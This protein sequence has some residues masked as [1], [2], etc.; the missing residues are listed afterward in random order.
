MELQQ[1]TFV[2]C[3]NNSITV[4][5]T[6]EDFD[7]R[8]KQG[9]RPTYFT[10]TEEKYMAEQ[11]WLTGSYELLDK[12]LDGHIVIYEHIIVPFSNGEL[13]G[14]DSKYVMEYLQ[15]YSATIEQVIEVFG[16]SMAKM[17][18]RIRVEV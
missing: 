2:R 9:Y 6:K 15:R 5:M 7:L 18:P 8:E 17:K 1:Q 14:E 3:T 13:Y 16:L 11:P 4:V 10:F 12:L